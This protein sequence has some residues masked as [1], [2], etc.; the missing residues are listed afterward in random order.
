MGVFLFRSAALDLYEQPLSHGL[1]FVIH[2]PVATAFL[3]YRV[4]AA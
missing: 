3:S 2:Y 4:R 1:V